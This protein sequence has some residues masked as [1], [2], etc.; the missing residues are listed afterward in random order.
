MQPKFMKKDSIDSLLVNF[1]EAR[2]HYVENDRDWFE[3]RLAHE[4][5][6]RDSRFEF[7][8]FELTCGAGEGTE[9]E[10]ALTDA[11]NV[12]IVYDAMRDLPLATAADQ[13]FWAGLCHTDLW[14]Y[15]QYRRRK[16]LATGKDHDIKASF[17]FMRGVKRSAHIHCVSRLWWAGR[18]SYDEENRDDPYALSDLFTSNA[19]A[20]RLM[21]FSSSNL[22]ANKST[23][24]GILDAIQEQRD[25][26]ITLRREHFV[27]ATKCLNRMGAITILDYLGRQR[28]K[29]IIS[30]YFSTEEFANLKV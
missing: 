8:D 19:F 22:T 13:R 5:G 15:V 6:L 21:L 11:E 4:H 1:D 17:F 3:Q 23:T 14:D 27:G 29:S 28:V 16:A 7:P 9:E 10:Y 20:S 2:A 24:L 12:R 30:D 26:G 18:L 25:A